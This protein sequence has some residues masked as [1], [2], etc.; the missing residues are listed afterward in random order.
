MTITQPVLT[1]GITPVEVTRITTAT[2]TA[3]VIN[4]TIWMTREDNLYA[5]FLEYRVLYDNTAGTL[6]IAEGALIGGETAPAFEVQ[7]AFAVDGEDI[8]IT[9]ALNGV[10]TVEYFCRTK[11]EILDTQWGG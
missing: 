4:V 9:C 1:T 2:N 11:F 5:Q 7:E 6:F 3:G 10:D 8:V